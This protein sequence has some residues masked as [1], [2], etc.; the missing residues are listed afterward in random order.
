MNA[1]LAALNIGRSPLPMWAFYSGRHEDFLNGISFKRIKC[2]STGNG[3][4]I[5]N[6]CPITVIVQNFVRG[7]ETVV[8]DLD[9]M[10]AKYLNICVQIC[11]LMPVRCFCLY[12]HTYKY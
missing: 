10:T 2:I 11:V 9:T 8:G 3:F 7:W 1:V 5:L 12:I 4:I 6:A